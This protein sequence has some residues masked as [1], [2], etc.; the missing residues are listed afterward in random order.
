MVRM[1]LWFRRARSA[2]EQG[3]PMNATTLHRAALA[4]AALLITTVAVAAPPAQPTLIF[5]AAPKQVLFDWNYV[6][7]AN[8]YEIWFQ[9]NA[10][11]PW[12]KIGERPSWYPHR[13]VNVS[14][15]LLDWGD[16]RW[17]V[18]ACNPSGCS[19]PRSVDIGSTVVNTVGY[20]KPQ[21]PQ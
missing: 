11:A 4:C 20:V 19:T 2:R 12:A 10:A 6:P 9:A 7:K 21:Q 16:S 15:H 3:E 14:A 17:D 8:Y 18:R 13:D 1:L 5:D